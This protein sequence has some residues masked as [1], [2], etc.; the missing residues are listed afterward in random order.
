[1]IICWPDNV[2]DIL[3]GMTTNFFLSLNKCL[4]CIVS[5]YSAR[6]MVKSSILFNEIQMVS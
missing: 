5:F 4:L 2:M 6:L 1:M 3:D